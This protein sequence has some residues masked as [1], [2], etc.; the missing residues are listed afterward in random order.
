MKVTYERWMKETAAFGRPRSKELKALDAALEAYRDAE[1]NGT[2]SVLKERQSLKQ[3][4][5]AWKAAKG[6]NWRQSVRNKFKTVELLDAELSHV[7]VGKGGLNS[8][9]KLMIDAKELAT[10]RELARLIKNNTRMLFQGQRLTV[11]N[12]AALADLNEVRGTISEFRSKVSDVRNAVGAAKPATG[13]VG[14]SQ[15]QG[16]LVS[17]FGDAPLSEIQQALGPL[18]TEFVSSV[19]PFVG[20]ISSGG[21]AIMNWSRA[22]VTLYKRHDMMN[23]AGASFAPGDPAAAFEAILCIMDREMHAYATTASIH[24]ISAGAKAA[25]TAAD[26]G[27]LSGTLLGAAETLAL[28]VQKIYLFARDWKETRDFNALLDQGIYDLN[29]FRTSPIVGCYLIANSDTAAIINMAV[30]DYGKPGWKFE[31][32]A[33]VRKAQPVFDR[34]REV[35]KASRFEFAGLRGMKGS[36]INWNQTTLGLPS[37]KLAGLVEEAKEKINRVAV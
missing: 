3:A 7:I 9:G 30:A 26:F 4:L 14:Q 16:L 15:V 5:D 29:L 34:A 10:A 8:R 25:F 2:G 6:P 19:T 23:S 27:A 31:V 17:L 28:T 12:T 32:E 22:A 1:L 21:K 36:A 13:A 37:G 18:A 33:M 11:K 35:I 20:A 24:T